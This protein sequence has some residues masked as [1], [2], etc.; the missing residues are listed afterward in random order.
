MKDGI[1]DEFYLSFWDYIKIIGIGI[2]L[3][4]IFTYVILKL[5]EIV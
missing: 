2:I 1:T 3:A 4:G 5:L